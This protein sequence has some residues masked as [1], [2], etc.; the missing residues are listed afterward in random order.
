[1]DRKRSIVGTTSIFNTCNSS[2][3]CEFARGTRSPTSTEAS[4]GNRNL[5]RTARTVFPMFWRTH[6]PSKPT[7]NTPILTQQVLGNHKLCRAWVAAFARARWNQNDNCR[8]SNPLR[9]QRCLWHAQSSSIR[10]RKSRYGAK[11]KGLVRNIGFTFFRILRLR[12]SS[13]TSVT[14]SDKWMSWRPSASR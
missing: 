7:L 12:N 1:M 6:S 9:V 11:G 8:I 14:W 13:K 2:R 4:Q 5:P 10:A 3:R